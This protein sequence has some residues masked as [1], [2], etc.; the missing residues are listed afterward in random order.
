[1]PA[2]RPVGVMST[3]L[4]T[5]IEGSTRL[6]DE[7]AE[8][9]GRPSPST[10]DSSATRSRPAAAQSIKTTGDG[11]LAVFGDPVA[12]VDAALAAQRA[13]ARRPGARPARCRVRMAL[14]SGDSGS[15]RRRLLRPRPQ[16]GRADPGDRPRRPDRLLSG[17]RRARRRASAAVRSSS[18]ILA[19]TACATSTAP[20]RSTRSSSTT[21]R[22][23]SHRFAR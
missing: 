15:P 4:F 7:H 18:S 5:D 10:T 2:A 21:C 6:W 9:W 11:I 19:L 12:A 14:H 17:H 3:F 23:R 16:P 20:S 1:M 13:F 22:G 8:G